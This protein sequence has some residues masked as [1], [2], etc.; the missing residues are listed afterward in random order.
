MTWDP[1]DYHY[2]HSLRART[3]RISSTWLSHGYGLYI[4]C[5]LMLILPCSLCMLFL[6][7]CLCHAIVTVACI[8]PCFTIMLLLCVF[9]C[10]VEILVAIAMFTMCLMLLLLVVLGE[11]WCPI[12]IYIWPLTNTLMI[13]CSYLAF[14][15]VLWHVNYSCTLFAHMTC[16]PWLPPVCCIFA[17]LACLTWSLWLPALSHHPCSILTRF[18]GLMTYM[19]MPLTWYILII[20]SLSISCLSHIHLYWVQPYYAYWSWRLWHF[21]CDA[22]LFDWAYCIWLY[23]HLMPPYYEMLPCPFLWW[24]W[25]IHLLGI[26]PHEW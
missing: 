20:V 23:S 24:A 5:H 2:D 14:M 16:L 1:V 11:S 26:L 15:L 12:A 7:L 6:L 4:T 25:C 9:A 3:T 22:C 21:P 17:L 19:F 13:F 8:H 18:L 10:L